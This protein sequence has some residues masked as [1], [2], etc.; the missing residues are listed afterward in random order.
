MD[1]SRSETV[2]DTFCDVLQ[3]L[4][5][6]FAEPVPKHELATPGGPCVEAR[7]GF[8]GAM[9]G[10]VALAVPEDTCVEIAANVLGMD[11]EDEVVMDRAHDALKEVLNITCGQLLVTL[12]GK[13]P[14][15]DL[16]VPAVTDVDAGRW[17]ELLAEEHAIALLVEEQAAILSFRM[18]EG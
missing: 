12:A 13:A 14:L 4:A 18:D 15:F 1:S 6:M 16:S 17:E 7:M 2:A 3:S 10:A 9:Q 8:S 5:F 11:A